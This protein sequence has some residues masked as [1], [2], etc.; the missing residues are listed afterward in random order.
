M[1]TCASALVHAVPKQKWDILLGKWKSILVSQK[2]FSGFYGF[3]K[4]LQLC[5]DYSKITSLGAANYYIRDFM[6]CPCLLN[7]ILDF[8]QLD[9]YFFDDRAFDID[10]KGILPNI[11]K[12]YPNS[13]CS[14]LFITWQKEWISVLIL[15]TYQEL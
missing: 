5:S 1:P 2:Q 12:V 7:I 13:L 3:W 6:M 11:C 10:T 15:V 9:N 8:A 4:A 14:E